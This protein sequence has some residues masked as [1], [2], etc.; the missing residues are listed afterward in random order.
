MMQGRDSQSPFARS[1]DDKVARLQ[2]V[3]ARFQ[4]SSPQPTRRS[5]SRWSSGLRVWQWL[6]AALVVL[7]LLA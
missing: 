2:H 5:G 1:E 7:A 6:V 3:R 4:A